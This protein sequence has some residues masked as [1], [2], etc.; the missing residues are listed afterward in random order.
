M[1]SFSKAFDYVEDKSK[2]AHSMTFLRAG[3]QMDKSEPGF[4][5][6]GNRVVCLQNDLAE[7]IDRADLFTRP[8]GHPLHLSVIQTH[9]NKTHRSNSVAQAA[10]QALRQP[11]QLAII[12]CST[13][14]FRISGGGCA[15]Y[16]AS[17]CMY[18]LTKVWAWGIR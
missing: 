11:D 16:A 9:T 12:G 6:S 7:P 10:N 1:H 3:D 14:Y 13:E 8:P 17:H 5:R 18:L 4:I 15:F 2:R